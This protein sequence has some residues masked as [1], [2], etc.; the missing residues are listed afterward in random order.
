VE[1]KGGRDRKRYGGNE[2]NG[3]K[4]GRTIAEIEAERDT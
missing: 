4:G 3:G 1:K 2:G